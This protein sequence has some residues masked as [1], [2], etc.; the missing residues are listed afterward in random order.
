MKR[1]LLK[2]VLK[3]FLTSSFVL[4]CLS[5][6]FCVSYRRLVLFWFL[7]G[8]QWSNY[9]FSL[10]WIKVWR[11]YDTN[12]ILF[13]IWKFWM[14]IGMTSGTIFSVELI[15]TRRIKSFMGEEIPW[16]NSGWVERL[17]LPTVWNLYIPARRILNAFPRWTA[18]AMF[19]RNQLTSLGSPV[20]STR[21]GLSP[22]RGLQWA[23]HTYISTTIGSNLC[24]S[25]RA[26]Y[27]WC[28]R[29]S[30]QFGGEVY[31]GES[32]LFNTRAISNQTPTQSEWEDCACPI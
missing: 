15:K 25:A 20:A 12:F 4:T 19:W 5:A 30:A 14:N 7:R 31:P 29:S 8:S 1:I 22:S 11:K 2:A 27:L 23:H 18:I 16:R 21:W 32:I 10:I 28:L 6:T 3:I 26:A 17:P 13:I 9:I 24:A